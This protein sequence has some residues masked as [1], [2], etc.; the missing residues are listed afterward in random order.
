MKLL[1]TSFL[2]FY[3]TNLY[4]QKFTSITAD[5]LNQL[6]ESQSDTTYVI[7]F[8]ATWCKPCIAEM[9]EFEELYEKYRDKKVKV[10]FVSIDLKAHIKKRLVPF[11]EKKQLQSTVFHLNEDK[12]SQWIDKIDS[13]WS[14]A[15]PATL[16]VSKSNNYRQFFEKEFTFANLENIVNPLTN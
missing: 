8:W 13:S 1:F 6:T 12:P 14:G 4:G 3:L 16:V 10:I 2:L 5:Q 7:N 11:L 9:P 15:I